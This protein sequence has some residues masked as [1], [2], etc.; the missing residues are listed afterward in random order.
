M[1]FVDNNTGTTEMPA[2]A[3]SQ[4]T[5]VKWFTEG[6][7]NKG[8][9]HIGQ[10]WLNIVQ[11]ELLAILT[12]AKIQPDKTKLNQ[13]AQAI[14]AIITASAF[15]R[16]NNLKEIASA[17]ASAQ[18]AARAN[19]GLG[20]LAAKGSLAASDVGAL[21]KSQNLADVPDKAAARKNLDVYSKAEGD[22][23]YL[24]K[25]AD[26]GGY[27][28]GESDGAYL[29]KNQNG[30][31]VPDKSAFID[32]LGL[33]ETVNQAANALPSTG[34]AVAANRLATPVNIN[35]V[36]FDGSRDINIVAGMSQQEADGRY[37]SNAQYGAE[38]RH[39][40]GGN[41]ISWVF[42]SPD[43]CSLSGINVQETGSNSADNI[44]AVFYKPLQIFI[45]GYW[46][47]ISG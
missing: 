21:E 46:R 6:D 17:G 16:T 22:A 20:A 23:R 3:P 19:L 1:Y 18:A 43:G 44:G 10:D 24:Q 28:R 13:L 45:S 40:P 25:G 41:Q 5:Q 14:K 39:D 4:G 7:G 11:A 33:R 15:L 26:T 9:S 42:K 35:G 30:R 34:T 8:I 38:S 37:I 36:S 32:N 31:D 2:L 12:E 27:S 29:Q 47:T